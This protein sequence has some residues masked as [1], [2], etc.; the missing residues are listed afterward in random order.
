MRRRSGRREG[1]RV[2]PSKALRHNA[3]ALYALF[4]ALAIGLTTA[5]F[6]LVYTGAAERQA[7]LLSAMVAFGIQL[8]AFSIAR[9]MARGGQV[10]A[11][12]SL[13]AAICFVTLLVYGFV[14]RGAGVPTG[15]ALVSL[16]TFLFITELIE[17]PLL[18]I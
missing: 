7:V 11:G 16:A 18:S 1:R 5:V 8:V 12:W 9:L 15:A 6:S 4:S 3:F 2:M 13:G 14:V 10:I 17:P